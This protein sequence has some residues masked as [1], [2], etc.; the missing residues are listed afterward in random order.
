MN[1]KKFYKNYTVF[2]TLVIMLLVSI[3]IVLVVSGLTKFISLHGKEYELPDFTGMNAKQ[4]EAFKSEENIHN[5]RLVINDSVFV[6]DKKGGI[7]LSQDPTAGSK[8]KKGRKVYFSIVALSMPNVEMPNLVDLSLRQAENMLQSNDLQ[9]GQVIYKA[10]KYP[11]AVLEQRYKGRIIEEGTF[12]PYQSK[13][14]LIVG[15]E[16]YFGEELDDEI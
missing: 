9:L 4:I 11:N 10:S 3:I 12:V 2:S 13:I 1:I 15:K 14:T 16:S 7:I 5:Y 6:P 8:V